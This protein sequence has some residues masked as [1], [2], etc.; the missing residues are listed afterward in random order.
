LRP[1]AQA[2]ETR[3]REGEER[4][5][6]LWWELRGVPLRPATGATRGTCPR[7]VTPELGKERGSTGS[8]RSRNCWLLPGAPTPQGM[9]KEPALGG[10]LRG[11]FK[12]TRARGLPLV[13]SVAFSENPRLGCEARETG[14][15]AT[16]FRAGE[17]A[18]GEAVEAGKGE[19]SC[20]GFPLQA[21]PRQSCPILTPLFLGDPELFWDAVRLLELFSP[22]PEREAEASPLPLDAFYNP[23]RERWGSEKGMGADMSWGGQF[24]FS[25]FRPQTKYTCI[26]TKRERKLV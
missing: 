1:K 4:K 13:V 23:E 16:G 26:I 19:E 17:A 18:T 9:G 5:S 12:G 10:T 11:S 14:F 21:S 24:T 6:C 3:K 15:S 25:T 7:P 22:A 20:T 8:V 2:R